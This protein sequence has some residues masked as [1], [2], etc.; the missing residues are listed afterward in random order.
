MVA[1]NA[2]AGLQHKTCFHIAEMV[3]FGGGKVS[4]LCFN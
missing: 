4:Q 2:A 3:S 1:R